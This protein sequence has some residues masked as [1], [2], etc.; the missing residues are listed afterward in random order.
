MPQLP[1]APSPGLARPPQPEEWRRERQRAYA[2]PLEPSSRA[3]AIEPNK[4]PV[5]CASVKAW[6]E[7]LRLDAL[8]ST[9]AL[10]PAG[11]A[12]L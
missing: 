3:L 6:E 11:R 1:I 10:S 2:A 12:R 5:A 4:K 9:P 8:I 7:S